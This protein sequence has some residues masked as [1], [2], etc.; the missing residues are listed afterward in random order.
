[1][2]FVIIFNKVLCMYMHI[3]LDIVPAMDWQ[4]DRIGKKSIV[5]C[6]HCMMTRGK[7]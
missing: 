4:T 5:L 2:R 3:R 7:K 6:M 1:M